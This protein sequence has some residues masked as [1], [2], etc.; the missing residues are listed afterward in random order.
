M[1]TPNFAGLL[2]GILAA[3]AASAANDI[4][5][6]PP[7][8]NVTI[9]PIQAPPPVV[10][11]VPTL[12]G[13]AITPITPITPIAPIV[14]GNPTLQPVTSTP[15]PASAI[16]VKSP[17][18]DA[19]QPPGPPVKPATGQAPVAG[20]VAVGSEDVTGSLM[21]V[22]KQANKDA[23]ED[24]K[25]SKTERGLALD[26][27]KA[28]LNMDNAS[29]K[30]GM[31]ESKAKASTLMNAATTSMAMGV[32]AG[33]LQAGAGAS[34]GGAAGAGGKA[35]EGAG[36]AAGAGA[37][38]A[39]KD[40]KPIKQALTPLDDPRLKINGPKIQAA[41]KTNSNDDG[42]K[43]T[44]TGDDQTARVRDTVNK[45]LEQQAQQKPKL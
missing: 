40:A 7:K 26:A 27:K 5:V 9:Q 41:A 4:I 36:G 11:A 14:V 18:V 33:T 2:L 20:D 28:K 44:S 19:L 35:G 37:S 42:Q 25:M 10:K 1:K 16:Q 29:I 12:P 24:H 23:R 39:G 30:N 43:A 21:E 31:D 8:L 45:L 34:A 6:A 38:G 32:A 13:G 22:Q 17:A 15:L 3:G